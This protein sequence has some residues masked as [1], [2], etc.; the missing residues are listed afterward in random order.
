MHSRKKFPFRNRDH[1]VTDHTKFFRTSAPSSAP[2]SPF[3]GASSPEP[4]SPD[5][6][7][8]PHQMPRV[9]RAMEPAAPLGPTPELLRR[10]THQGHVTLE[11]SAFAAASHARGCLS[12]LVG[13]LQGDRGAQPPPRPPGSCFSTQQ[14]RTNDGL[15]AFARPCRSR[16]SLLRRIGL[17]AHFECCFRARTAR[18]YKYRASV[19]LTHAADTS[20][21]LSYPGAHGF[22]ALQPLN[23]RFI[24][25]CW[26]AVPIECAMSRS[27]DLDAQRHLVTQ[28]TL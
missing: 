16:A 26:L 10:G 4:A 2:L 3:L 18:C 22:A 21:I 25:C 20:T 23:C 13:G 24:L 12:K 5:F 27:Q 19:A 11:G 7:R 9:S 8:P 14:H 28:K 15:R 6:L 1:N 17:S